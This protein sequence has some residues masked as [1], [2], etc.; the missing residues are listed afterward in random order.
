MLPRR[1]GWGLGEGALGALGVHVLWIRGQLHRSVGIRGAVIA[2]RIAPRVVVLPHG[3]DA[4]PSRGVAPR[5]LRMSSYAKVVGFHDVLRG[6]PIFGQGWQARDDHHMVV[7]G[8]IGRGQGRCPDAPLETELV[9][10]TLSDAV[11]RG[12][13]GGRLERSHDCCMRMNRVMAIGFNSVVRS[14]PVFLG[15]V[16]VGSSQC[17]WVVMCLAVAVTGV[18]FRLHPMILGEVL[19]VLGKV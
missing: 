18:R 3:A 4:S 5:V 11:G 15:G 19:G 1:A 6:C 16:I 17:C 7:A 10:V 12:V 2:P 9:E 14:H 13:L 8:R